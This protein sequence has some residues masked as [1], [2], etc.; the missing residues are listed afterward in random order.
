M[1]DFRIS[2]ASWSPAAD[3]STVLYCSVAW[4]FFF[5]SCSFA[6]L[7]FLFCFVLFCP[8][9]RFL[10]FLLSVGSLVPCAD[11]SNAFT[12]FE[13][14]STFLIL[15]I[16]NLVNLLATFWRASDQDNIYTSAYQCT[17][18]SI[19]VGSGYGCWY[20]IVY[21]RT[22]TEYYRNSS[23]RFHRGQT[24]ENRWS[25]PCTHARCTYSVQLSVLSTL[26]VLRDDQHLPPR[27]KTI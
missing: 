4:F 8:G 26:A 25:R 21:C 11:V 19:K 14:V 5:F 17:N 1:S 7:I 15:Y 18:I 9:L 10:A 24:D 23:S 6:W 13:P 16:G 3:P 12:Y 2:G 20:T 27:K 22:S